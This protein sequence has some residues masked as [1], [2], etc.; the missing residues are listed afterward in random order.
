MI[1]FFLQII[2]LKE[3][4]KQNSS[5]TFQCECIILNL[6]STCII[7]EVYSFQIKLVFVLIIDDGA[8]HNQGLYWICL[9]CATASKN[10][11]YI[12]F[13][14]FSPNLNKHFIKSRWSGFQDQC[15]PMTVTDQVIPHLKETDERHLEAGG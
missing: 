1:F 12:M 5:S 15:H 3:K 7:F 14:L 4:E 9:I 6:I 10:I 13:M 8:D 11:W 2:L